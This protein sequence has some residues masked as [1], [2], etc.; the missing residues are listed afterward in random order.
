MNSAGLWLFDSVQ[1]EWMKA[2]LSTCCDRCGKRL[3]THLPALAVLL[4]LERRLHQRADGIDEE[5]GRLVE[6]RQFLAVV[7]G[8]FR[9]IVPGI[10]LAGP[11]VDKDPDYRL[12]LGGDVRLSAS[13]HWGHVGGRVRRPA[14][15][16]RTSRF[17]SASIPIPLPQ[18][19]RRSRRL[20][21][22][23]GGDDQ[24]SMMLACVSLFP[25]YAYCCMAGKACR[26]LLEHSAVRLQE[27]VNSLHIHEL[28]QTQ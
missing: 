27:D 24:R 20:R 16:V 15:F 26:E 22:E 18:R 1:S 25:D 8:Q 28:V 14:R 9:L 19:R 3:D 21:R 4:E 7:F 12:G 11:A 13:G 5:A 6:A 2:I 17:A 10:D 23:G